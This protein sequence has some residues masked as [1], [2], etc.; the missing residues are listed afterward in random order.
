MASDNRIKGLANDVFKSYITISRLYLANNMIG[1]KGI[2]E[3]AFT[4]LQGLETLDLTNNELGSL[5]KSL[6]SLPSLTTLLLA[7]N[8]LTNTIFPP[9]ELISSPLVVLN[10]ADNQLDGIPELGF[11]PTLT[12]MN[13]SNNKLIK[14][15]TTEKIASYC[16]LK[17][18]DFSKI[19]LT[20][21]K[22]ECECY[23]LK[24]WIKLHQIFTLPGVRVCNSAGDNCE[25]THQFS[26]ESMALN[27][28]CEDARANIGLRELN[29]SARFTWI[30]S[31]VCIV[32]FVVVIFIALCCIHR[33]KNK[34]SKAKED[35]VRSECLLDCVNAFCW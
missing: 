1:F 32:A 18:L 29:K 25:L 20:F 33:C 7:D 31:S 28:A 8:H 9:A 19:N 26:N 21:G 3:D 16:S 22:A 30:I 6:L 14:E 2:Q 10:L 15:L 17:K 4:P 11:I 35:D 5:P 24:K 12:H 34:R 27:S 13:I 23:N